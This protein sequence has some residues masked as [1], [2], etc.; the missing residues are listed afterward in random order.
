MRML[1][2]AAGM[3]V[4][5]TGPAFAMGG[6]SWSSKVDVVAEAPKVAPDVTQSVDIV[7]AELPPVEVRLGPVQTASLSDAKIRQ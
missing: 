2:L 1:V 6:C 5:M 7:V 3:A 4:A